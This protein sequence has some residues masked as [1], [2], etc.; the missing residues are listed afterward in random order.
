MGLEL[1]GTWGK[2]VAPAVVVR[3]YVGVWRLGWLGLG[4]G[5]W[6]GME[7]R[8][9]GR[10]PNVDA[11]HRSGVIGVSRTGAVP[12]RDRVCILRTLKS[13]VAIR[14][15]YRPPAVVNPVKMDQPVNVSRREAVRSACGARSSEPA[16]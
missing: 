2:W 3:L 9:V 5:G 10:F 8:G 13:Q 14:Q 15:R 7:S 16:H 4:H 1:V 6:G 11:S 12:T